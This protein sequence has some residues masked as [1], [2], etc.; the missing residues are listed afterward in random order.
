MEKNL[1][2]ILIASFALIGIMIWVV[3]FINTATI[4]FYAGCTAFVTAMLS[5]LVHAVREAKGGIW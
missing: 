2:N 5:M 3:G 1:K 4:I